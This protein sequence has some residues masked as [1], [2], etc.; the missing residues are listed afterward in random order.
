MIEFRQ[1]EFIAP[2]IAALAPAVIQGG[3]GIIQGKKANE[4]QEKIARQQQVQAIKERKAQEQQ[5]NQAARLQ[6]DQ[7]KAAQKQ[8]N[9]FQVYIVKE[10]FFSWKV[11]WL[12]VILNF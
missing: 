2:I 7:L 5:A 8:Q 1:K 11:L 3:A 12:E 4:S 9:Q 6:N 10:Q